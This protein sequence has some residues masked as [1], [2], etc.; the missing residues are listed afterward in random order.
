MSDELA[1]TLRTTFGFAAFRSGQ[2]EAIASLLHG[3]HTLVVMPTGA[4]KSLVYQLGALHRPGVTLVISPLIALMKDQV[5]ALARRGIAA[6]YINSTVPGDEQAARLNALAGGQ[7]RLVYVAPERLRS[8]PFRQALRQ[9]TLGLLAVDEAHC[10]SQWGHDF[11]PDYLHIGALRADLGNPLTAALTATATPQV[12]D[13]IVAQLGLAEVERVITGF[14][15]PNLSF[16]VRSVADDEAKLHAIQH[17]LRGLNDGAAI[18]YAGTRRATEETADFVRSLGIDVR[19]YHAGLDAGARTLVQETFMAGD[20]PVVVATNAF[21]MGIDRADVRMVIHCDMPGTLET[22]YQEAGR[23]GRDGE[24][25]RAVL[26]YCPRDRALQEWF[27]DNDAPSAAELRRRHDALRSATA[28]WISRDELALATGLPDAKIRVGLAQLEAS[29]AVEHLGD[30]GLRMLLQ[31][32]SWHEGMAQARAS[33]VHERRRQ[34][35]RQL[36]AMVSYAESNDCRRRI[37]LDHF[38]DRGPADATVCCD[39]CQARATAAAH[40]S[41]GDVSTMSQAERAALIILDAVRRMAWQTGRSKLANMLRGSRSKEMTQTGYDKTTYY[42]RLSVY[43]VAELEAM[44]DQMLS[45]GYL[46]QVGGNRPVL[47]LTRQGLAALKARA[48]IPLRLPRSVPQETVALKRAEREAGS[49][50]ALSLQMLTDGL[51]PAQIA[52][53][54]VLSPDT[55]YNHLARYIADGTVHLDHV[56]SADVAATV[57][58]A[59]DKAGGAERLAPLKMALPTTISY[60]EIR[61]VAE[62]WKRE[63]RAAGDRAP[64]AAGHEQGGRG[65]EPTT[66]GSTDAVAAFLERAHPRALPGPWRAGWALGFHSSFGGANWQRSA[67]GDLAYRAK[68]QADASAVQ[69][70]VAQAAALCEQEPALAEVDALAAVPP[71]T[72]RA[73]DAAAAFAAGLAATLGMPLLAALRKTR[74]TAPQKEFHTAAQKRANVAGAFAVTADV[75]GKRLLVVD[76]LY[77]SGATL[78]EVTRVLL[79]AGAA[80]VCVLTMTRTIHSDR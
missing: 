8:I 76:D 72:A 25:A 75:R 20:V 4:G 64:L 67:V 73:L 34:R 62:A 18:P 77:D 17:L 45:L 16:E 61:C 29:G 37:I 40:S 13:V 7:L 71:T 22:Y 26:L 58:A 80:S 10:I 66:D 53:R 3:R 27:I 55:I 57:R 52:A 65:D 49:T 69:P 59:I 43:R 5:D 79:Q 42:G 56:V 48:P 1:T 28:D 38:G 39:N 68:Y 6:T 31:R 33:A 30:D 15:R 11:R 14:N 32:G 19:F 2:G 63:Q 78:S 21:G 74:Q 23:A 12:Q 36:E 24:L 44:I 54:R 70:L 50:Y 9:A 46:K 35:R 51:T 47:R 41:A 60:G